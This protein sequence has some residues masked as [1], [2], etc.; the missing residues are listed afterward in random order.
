M[1]FRTYEPYNEN[2]EIKTI[3]D[4]TAECFI[5]FE[6]IDKYSQ[7]VI[8][9]NYQNE[10]LNVCQCNG[11]VHQK[12]LQIWI[13]KTNKCPICRNLIVKI[14]NKM[15]KKIA[16]LNPYLARMILLNK[17]L[18]MRISRYIFT[19]LFVYLLFD[20]YANFFNYLY[21]NFFFNKNDDYPNFATNYDNFY[22]FF[23]NNNRN[24]IIYDTTNNNNWI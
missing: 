8:K 4:T 21:L 23:D 13:E 20:F 9:L 11:N 7:H 12:C 17:Y 19:C 24:V 22:I 15:L 1:L 10:Y 18:L 2:E 3:I 6:N 16:C 14:N 5:C